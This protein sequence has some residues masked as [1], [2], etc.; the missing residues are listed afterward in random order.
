MARKYTWIFVQFLE[1]MMSA[2][3]YLSIL[4]YSLYILKPYGGYHVYWPSNIFRKTCG[5]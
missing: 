4:G 1:Q 2:D 5:F 3:K